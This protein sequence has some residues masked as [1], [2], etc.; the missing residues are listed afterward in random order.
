MTSKIDDKYSTH[1]AQY[2]KKLRQPDNE[3]WS[4]NRI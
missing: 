1:N 2:L 3:I 4:F